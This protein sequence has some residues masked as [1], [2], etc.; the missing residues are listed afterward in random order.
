MN[1]R[2]MNHGT[3]LLSNTLGRARRSLD[4]P[5]NVIVDPYEMGYWGILGDRNPRG[6]YRDFTAR[7]PGDR[8]EYDFD[9]S[10]TLTVPGDWNTQDERLLYY[11]GTVWYRRKLTIRPEDVMGERCF[12]HV[13]AAN[14]S[15]PRVRRRRGARDTRRRVRAIRR[16]ADRAARTRRTLDRHPGRQP[17]RAGPDPGDAVRLVELRRPHTFG[18][19]LSDPRRSSPTPGSRWRRTG[20]SSADT[21]RRRRPRGAARTARARRRHDGRAGVRARRR[22]R[23]LATRP[24]GAARRRLALRRDDDR[25]PRRLPHRRDRRPRHRRQR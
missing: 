7:H 2:G 21:G 1:G 6:F 8:V 11:E 23:A 17:S 4:G 24:A 10:P 13:G 12:L 16:R 22:P 3:L 20:A 18:R 14:H 9:S 25:R 19:P 5:W 15:S